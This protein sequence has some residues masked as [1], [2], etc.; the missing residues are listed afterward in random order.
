MLKDLDTIAAV[1]TPWG[2]GGVGVVRVSGPGAL[3]SALPL[4]KPAPSGELKDRYL[5]YGRI[6]DGNN[7]IDIGFL[8]LMRAPRSY[9]GE[10]VVELHCH[11]GPLILMK[12]LE[13]L[14]KNG[15][16][17]AGPGEFTR[18]AF[19]NGKLDLA[20]AEAV[21]DIIKAETEL[22]LSGARGRLEGGLSRKVNAIKEGLVSLLAHIEAELD[23][24]EDEVEGLA[25]EQILKRLVEAEVSINRLVA[26]Y[27]EGKAIRD[28]IGVLILGRPNVGKSSL[29]NILL[30]EERA[31]VTPHPGTTRD[32]IEE[33]VNI[34]GLP[35]RLMD[36]A[37]LRDTADHVEAIGVRL[38]RDRV[39]S[40]GL[41][42]FVVDS[43]S[44]NYDEDIRFLECAEG[45]KVLILANK[46]DLAIAKKIESVREVFNARKT[47]F[48]SALL[49]SGIEDLKDMIY[50]EAVGR[51][52]GVRGEAP[53]GELIV[54]LRHKSS[55]LYSLEGIDRTKE[56][57]TNGA[58]KEFIATDLRWSVD[59]L[60]EITG[61]TTTE[62]I[63]DRI[64]GAF[65]IGK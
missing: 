57:V 4:F 6:T 15:A 47:V 7:D 35:V 65:C 50:E 40:A 52:S 59:R 2:E 20:Q 29:L 17:Q 9:T 36:T 33:V 58:A 63:L 22:S 64:F 39:A 62:E 27:R 38:A 32:V 8:V 42:L 48:V 54:S 56:A 13:A 34:R 31:I 41:V 5:Y 3:A 14:V 10:D 45:K 16:R 46:T 30:K 51:A 55:L 43:T 37:G 28:G 19:M 25:A 60:G 24:P 26:T 61:E 49:S 44:D 53:E 18:R 21:S 23:F 1:A 11:G 12:V